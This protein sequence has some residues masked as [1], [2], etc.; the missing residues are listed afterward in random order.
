VLIEVAVGVAAAAAAA[1]V[2]RGLWARRARTPAPGTPVVEAPNA[3]AARGPGLAPGDVL[4]GL[5]QE[6]VLEMGSELDD[7]GLVLRVLDVLSA[8]RQHVLQLDVAGE[9]LVL[10]EPTEAVPAGRVADTVELEGRILGLVRRGRATARPIR[11][12]RP[13]S[14]W[15]SG[16]PLT[17][18]VAY[19]ILADRGGRHLV[20]L[21]AGTERLALRGDRLDRRQLDILPGS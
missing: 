8:R 11:S 4:T 15:P 2:A 5:G 18:E 16:A 13:P 1:A 14:A 21:E 12:D 19:V 3:S 20:V 6:Q 7:G 9:A 17:G 10:A